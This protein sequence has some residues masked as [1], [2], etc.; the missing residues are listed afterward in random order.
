MNLKK[1]NI[2]FFIKNNDEELN[3]KNIEGILNNNILSFNSDNDIFSIDINNDN[4]IMKKENNDSLMIFNFKKDEETE[5]KYYIKELNFY[6]DTKILTNN[7]KKESESLLIEY[8]LWLSNEYTGKF[9][10]EIL[11]KEL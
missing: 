9:R 8:E 6:I 3:K 2:D 1:Y 10:Y 4:I 11:M 7:I 5:T